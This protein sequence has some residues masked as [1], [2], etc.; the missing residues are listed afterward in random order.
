MLDKPFWR[1]IRPMANDLYY[2]DLKSPQYF[3]PFNT[4]DGINLIRS[5]HLLEEEMYDLFD[6]IEPSDRNLQCYSHRM[7]S[8]LLKAATEFEASSKAILESNSYTKPNN[9]NITDYYKINQAAKLSD[10]EVYIPIWNGNKFKNF[11]PLE[12]WSTGHTLQWYKDYNLAKHDRTKNFEKASLENVV[13]AVASV[14][15]IVFSQFNIYTF[16]PHNLI[17]QVNEGNG[18][19]IISHDSCRLQIKLPFAGSWSEGEHYDFF[20]T[21]LKDEQN[22]YQEYKF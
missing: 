13:C 11:K 10:Y 14:F 18:T 22:R 20:W 15:C 19:D 3:D 1:I 8:L 12:E 2:E 9:W 17:Y 6:Y 16:S 7:Q 5:Y 4:L 21:A